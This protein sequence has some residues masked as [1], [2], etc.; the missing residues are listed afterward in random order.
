MTEGRRALRAEQSCA[1]LDVFLAEQLGITRSA[2]KKL[3]DD[4]RVTVGGAPVK[5]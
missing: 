3:I 5:A 1:R 4:G 2:A